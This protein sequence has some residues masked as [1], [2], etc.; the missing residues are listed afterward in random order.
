MAN[1]EIDVG[2]PMF[3]SGM[4]YL[5]RIN[6]IMNSYVVA[7][8]NNDLEKCMSLVELLYSEIFPRLTE[9]QKKK[10]MDLELK[11]RMSFNTRI[12]GLIKLNLRGYYNA[13]NQSCNELGLLLQEKKSLID[14]TDD[15][16]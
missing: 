7:Y 13:L 12:M 5:Q 8:A 1:G 3:N 9:A 15:E 11:A 16:D 4:A 2:D 14:N 6:T 10:F